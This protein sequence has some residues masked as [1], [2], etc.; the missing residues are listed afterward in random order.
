M[1]ALSAATSQASLA[2]TSLDATWEPWIQLF[3]RGDPRLAV[4]H[5][6]R[7]LRAAEL[8]LEHREVEQEVQL[9]L[10]RGV[11]ALRDFDLSRFY[12]LLPEAGHEQHELALR[13]ELT[14]SAFV[15]RRVRAGEAFGV[16]LAGPRRALGD[17]SQVVRASPPKDE[18]HGY[19]LA[20]ELGLGI[21][22]VD[23]GD[24]SAG[25][26]TFL[27]RS[28]PPRNDA[29]S[30]DPIPEELRRL[31]PA[32]K[33]EDLAVMAPLFRAY[34]HMSQMLSQMGRID[35]VRSWDTGNDIQHIQLRLRGV[36]DRFARTHPEFARYMHKLDKVGRMSF[37]WLD[38]RGRTLLKARIDSET[39][40]IDVDCFLKEGALWPSVDGKVAQDAEP[41]RLTQTTPHTGRLIID[42]TVDLMGF[43]MTFAGFSIDLKFEPREAHAELHLRATQMPKSLDVTGA[44]FGFMPLGLVDVFIPGDVR[45]VTLE[46]FRVALEGNAGRGIALDAKLGAQARGG[47]GVLEIKGEIEAADNR[48]V[49]MAMATVNH[50]LVATPKAEADMRAFMADLRRGLAQDLGAYRA[51][52]H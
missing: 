43:S 44:A 51:Q 11:A 17:A 45:S 34:P 10:D 22:P 2:G 16:S 52:L 48:L 3:G 20:T 6:E 12:R 28:L 32:L 38:A 18:A 31:H 5:M 37:T 39:L 14:G 27:T 41:S 4:S 25:L 35:D 47:D 50:K 15:V 29:P 26:S 33:S 13:G 7:M 42:G 49:K 23:F 1:I 19:L 21:G 40:A 9:I 8:V 46:F 30:G 24:I 36:M